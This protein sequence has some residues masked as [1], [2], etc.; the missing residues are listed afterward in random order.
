MLLGGATLSE[1]SHNDKNR[2]HCGNETACSGSWQCLAKLHAALS[3][4]R[5][6]SV[7][8]VGTPKLPPSS[9]YNLG[10]SGLYYAVPVASAG[11]CALTLIMGSCY[12]DRPIFYAIG[13]MYTLSKL[14]VVT[15][16]VISYERSNAYIQ[17]TDD[18]PFNPSYSGVIIL[19]IVMTMLDVVIVGIEHFVIHSIYDDYSGDFEDDRDVFVATRSRRSTYV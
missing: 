11:C 3:R 9:W 5:V 4:P 10:L 17:S 6:D 1:C 8:L 12:W 19:L 16:A 13:V 2:Y 7:N 14:L 15:Y 18:V